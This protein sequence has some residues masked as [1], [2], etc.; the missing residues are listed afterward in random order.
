MLSWG[1]VDGPNADSRE[2]ARTLD[3]SIIAA[4]PIVFQPELRPFRRAI[5]PAFGNC[6]G[7]KKA[8]QA[9]PPAKADKRRSA[10]TCALAAA[11]SPVG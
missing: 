7:S 5:S 9:S 8:P 2:K 11:A 6:G 1:E 4:S 3:E 10:I